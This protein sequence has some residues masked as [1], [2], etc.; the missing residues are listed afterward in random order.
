M[1]TTRLIEEYFDGTLNSEE[2]SAVEERAA[3]DKGFHDLMLLHREVNESIRNNDVFELR[4]LI[5]KISR[6][7]L[8]TGSS[9]SDLKT[10]RFRKGSYLLFSRIA[11]LLIFAAAAGFVL[12][13]T[14]FNRMSAGRLYEK[15]YAAYDIDIFCRSVPV[16]KMPLDEAI[17]SYN[18]GKYPD[19]LKMLDEILAREQDNYM[20]LFY[21][22]LT[23]LETGDPESAVMSLREIPVNWVSPFNE[24]RDWYLA[25]ALLKT[26]KTSEASVILQK[27]SGKEGYYARQAKQIIRRLK[28]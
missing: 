23:C 14:V 9:V 19:A 26:D 15:Y 3:R 28:S 21:R 25:L 22:G 4:D 11:A 10:K 13:F 7:Y 17:M 5:A 2:R 16:N 8:V 1:E 27:I 20:A 6:D 18:Q 12:K 24:H